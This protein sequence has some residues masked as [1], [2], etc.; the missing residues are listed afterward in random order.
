MGNILGDYTGI[1]NLCE[2][3][4]GAQG[5]TAAVAIVD[6]V[7]E[8][9]LFG[10]AISQPINDPVAVVTG[11]VSPVVVKQKACLPCCGR[12]TVNV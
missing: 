10:S 8:E 3:V 7:V 12:N 9:P 5:E 2:G 11:D 1:C 4:T 6:P